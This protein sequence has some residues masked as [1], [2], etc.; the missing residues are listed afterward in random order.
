[1]GTEVEKCVAQKG[2]L[3]PARPTS[4]PP[5]ETWEQLGNR[6]RRKRGKT[7]IRAD[8]KARRDNKLVIA[9]PVCKTSISGSNPDGASIFT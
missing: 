7:R 2:I 9:D 4:E 6:T 5:P 8:Q 1:M 3:F